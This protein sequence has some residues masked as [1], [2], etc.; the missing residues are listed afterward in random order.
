ML[1]FIVAG[2]EEHTYNEDIY[3]M[4][5]KAIKAIDKLLRYQDVL[6]K[7]MHIYTNM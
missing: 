2:C 1:I 5:I 3:Y 4:Y 7:G 6:W